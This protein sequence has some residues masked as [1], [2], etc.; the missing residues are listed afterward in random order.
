MRRLVAL[1]DYRPVGYHDIFVAG[2]PIHA[3]ALRSSAPEALAVGF[4]TLLRPEL[5]SLSA[6]ELA[7]SRLS[8]RFVSSTKLMELI[9]IGE[10]Q[11]GWTTASVTEAMKTFMWP[12]HCN[13]VLRRQPENERAEL[14]RRICAMLR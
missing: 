6:C 8:K 1:I 14:H 4:T 10:T 11:R 5:V 3:P 7:M 2:L 9:E 13:D 12:A